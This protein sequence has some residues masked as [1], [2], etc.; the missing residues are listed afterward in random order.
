MDMRKS[1]ETNWTRDYNAETQKESKDSRRGADLHPNGSSAV[2]IW[3]QYRGWNRKAPASKERRRGID[4]SLY[5][6]N[7]HTSW[8]EQIKRNWSE[9]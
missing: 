8:T 3:Q 4:R 1:K 9:K 7:G 2:D 6:L 5:T